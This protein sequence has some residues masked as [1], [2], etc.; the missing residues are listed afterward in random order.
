[1]DRFYFCGFGKIGSTTEA[2]KAQRRDF[3]QKHSWTSDEKLVF[4]TD[5]VLSVG[6]S[7]TDK[8]VFLCALSASVVMRCLSPV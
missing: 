3:V 4:D 1:L 7:P 5:F 2:Q 6:I 8:T